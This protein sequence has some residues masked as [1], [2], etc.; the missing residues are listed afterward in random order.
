MKVTPAALIA[1][2]SIGARKCGRAGSRGPSTL[3][4]RI[5]SIEPSRVVGALCASA[6]GSGASIRSDTVGASRPK[7]W[8]PSAR[9]TAATGP[10]IS[11]GTQT[12]AMRVPAVPSSG[13]TARGESVSSMASVPLSFVLCLRARAA[14]GRRPWRAAPRGSAS[15]AGHPGRNVPR[16]AAASPRGGRFGRRADDAPCGPTSCRDA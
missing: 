12:R 4:A 5:S 10:D 16:I 14:R 6:A 2:R 15:S 9:R 11:P 3:L 13:S 1:C 8:T 7:A